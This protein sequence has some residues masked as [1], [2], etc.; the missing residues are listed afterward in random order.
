MQ[1]FDANMS[2]LNR[3]GARPL[4]TSFAGFL[5]AA[6]KTTIF[7]IDLSVPNLDGNAFSFS[8]GSSPDQV[9]TIQSAASPLGEWTDLAFRRGDGSQINFSTAVNLE[10]QFFRVQSRPFAG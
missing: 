9:F 7:A 3:R 10:R 8:F 4:I 5:V 2:L 6:F 1:K